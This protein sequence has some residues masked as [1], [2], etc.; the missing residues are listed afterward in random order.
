MSKLTAAQKDALNLFSSGADRLEI[1]VSGLSEKNLDLSLSPGEWT[2]RQIIHHLADDGDNMSLIF[3]KAVASPGVPIRFE[4]FPGN[5]AWADAL[6]FDKR[7]VKT[8]LLLIKTHRQLM[9]ELADY[10]ADDWQKT[11]VVVD[12]NGKEL[13][14]L[15]AGKVISLL[16][17]HMS[18]HISTIEAI[19]QK[20]GLRP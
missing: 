10:F 13:Q 12:S 15:S 2:I 19:K 9:A 6:A 5:E 11:V 1:I 20:H 18:E 4:G 3:K 16:A 8:A 14:K 7:P 17:G